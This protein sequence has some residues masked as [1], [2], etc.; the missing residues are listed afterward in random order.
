MTRY[1][2]SKILMFTAGAAIGSLV[3]WKFVEEKYKRIADE[4]IESM[5]EYY[6]GKIQDEEPEENEEEEQT[7]TDNKIDMREY[8]AILN[9][10]DYVD[11]RNVDAEE[12]SDVK[13]P[14]VIDP[15]EFDELSEEGYDSVTLYYFADG[16][17]ADEND[18]PIED[19][20]GSVGLDSLN[21]FG[22]YS[23][24][25]VYV[26]NDRLMTD[27]EILLDS[28]NFDDT[29]NKNLRSAED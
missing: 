9:E 5:R 21:H 13:K 3:T 8:A 25:S 10:N 7:E 22:E 15:N 23:D 18:I 24:D 2:L 14:Y 29:V 12:V 6:L 4:E 28:R 19:V 20:D 27:Y 1:T 17:L 26:R 11:Y 16:V